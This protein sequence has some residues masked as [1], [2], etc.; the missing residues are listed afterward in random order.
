MASVRHHLQEFIGNVIV[1]AVEPAHP[2]FALQAIDRLK[3][4]RERCA[5]AQIPPVGGNILRD[6]VNFPRPGLEQRLHLR[7]HRLH[8]ATPQMPAELRDGAERTGVVA[9]LGNLHIRKDAPRKPQRRKR[10]FKRSHG[11][12]P[13]DVQHRLF[14][15]R[16]QLLKHRRERVE[17]VNAEEGVHLREDLQHLLPVTLRHAPGN[18]DRSAR[19]ALLVRTRRK[20]VLRPLRA[21]GLNERAGVYEDNVCHVRTPRQAVTCLEQVPCHHFAVREVL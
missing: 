8:R 16:L 1:E 10:F 17:G 9:P 19:P 4:L 13:C 20:N 3:Q 11:Q 5:V 12:P 18:D 14:L 2:E 7:E 6:K 21:G 15:P